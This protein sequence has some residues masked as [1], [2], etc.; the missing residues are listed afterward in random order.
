MNE[1]LVVNFPFSTCLLS[2][3]MD[4]VISP[5]SFENIR[6][7]WYPE[8]NHHCPETPWLL[9]GMKCDLRSTD[10]PDN[11]PLMEELHRKFN[12][13]PI[14]YEEGCNLADELGAAG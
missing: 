14:T 2:Q 13:G 9:C 7:K 5:V 11:I 6:S 12:R 3:P 1:V 10:N 8:I 4:S